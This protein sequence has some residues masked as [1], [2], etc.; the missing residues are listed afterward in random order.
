MALPDWTA[1]GLPPVIGILGTAGTSSLY[2]TPREVEFD[3][4]PPRSRTQT[5]FNVTP[6]TY[7]G[8]WTRAQL[9]ALKTFYRVT[10]NKGARRF[11]APIRLA[12]GTLGPRTCKFAGPIVEQ[13][14]GAK[15]RVSF[16]LNVFDW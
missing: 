10:L 7:A 1:A 13:D 15:V 9:V 14:V 8:I 3:D 12:D 2:Q 11:T 6:R 4:G 5:I 16:T